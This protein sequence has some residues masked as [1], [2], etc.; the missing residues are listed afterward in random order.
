MQS[1]NFSIQRELRRNLALDLAY[2]GTRGT[3]LYTPG[4]NLNQLRPEQLGP[5]PNSAD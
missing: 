1:W 5:P 2:A 4:S 3:K